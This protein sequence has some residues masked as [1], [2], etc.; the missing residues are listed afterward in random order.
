MLLLKNKYKINKIKKPGSSRAFL[1]YI[2][3]DEILLNCPFK[4][5]Q[6]VGLKDSSNLL[7][8]RVNNWYDIL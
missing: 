8:R 3:S 4:N 2:F 5:I 6:V 1:F 7:Y